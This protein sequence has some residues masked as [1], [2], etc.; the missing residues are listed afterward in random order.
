MKTIAFIPVML[1]LCIACQTS[2]KS[3]TE[4]QKKV[5]QY[6]SI[7][8][9]SDL[10]ELSVHQK[11]LLRY[12]FEAA[13]IMDEIYWQQAYGDKSQ[14]LNSITDA[15]TRQF[16]LINYGPWERLNG[17]KPFIKNAGDKPLG[18]NFYPA[19]MT[20]EEFEALDDTL[21]NSPY[22]ILRRDENGNLEV[23]PYHVAYRELL[24]K[25]S[26]L[27][28]KASS[29]AS[30]PGFK[31]YLQLRAN[32]LLTDDYQPSD[33][34]WMDMNENVIDFV[35]G[36]IE[37]YEDQLFGI[38]TSY[39]AYIL[40]KDKEWSERL[41]KYA[42][43]LPALQQR[44]PVD[45]KYKAESPG[46]N[47][48]LA[49]YDVL[50]YAGDCNAGSKSIAINLPNDEKVQLLKGSRRLQLKNAMQAK[51]EKILL[52]M[53]NELIDSSQL[54]FITFDA[55]F[56]D[57][58]FHEVAHGLG[59]KNTLTGKGTVREA[60][61]EE[62]SALEEGKADILGLFL[63][64]QLSEMG[65]IQVDLRNNYTTF[66]AGIFRSVRFGSSSAHGTANLVRF[67][68]FNEKGAFTRSSEG[69]YKVDYN[70]IQ[71]AVNDLSKEILVIQ[72]NGDYDAAKRMIEKYGIMTPE[73]QGDLERINSKGIP[74]DIVFEQGPRV[75]GL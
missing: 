15:D 50:Y 46:S 53:A 34:A 49:A 71:A 18:A 36:P 9:S 69:K 19:D 2:Y 39:E 5:K 13:D 66:L 43:L 63:V 67:N 74:V 27:I 70:K 73:L 45:A 52:P 48:D 72:G 51:F 58:M 30:D 56:E 57:V 24:M 17:N 38:K 31:N 55:F 42:V 21:K 35:F 6:A 10:S 16:A 14:L 60:L 47:S 22:A 68:Y 65:E 8:L 44:L 28:Q 25:A 64:Y 11:E 40:L 7:Q 29:Y 37:N 23:I 62:Y 1:S 20:K 3:E 33:F 4:M 26:S 75:L 41:N 59:I 54:S 61:K 12:L 32:A